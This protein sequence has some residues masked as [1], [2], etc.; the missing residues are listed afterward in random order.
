MGCE[1]YFRNGVVGRRRQLRLEPCRDVR[2]ELSDGVLLA[3]V[4]GDVEGGEA[5]LP[6][7]LTQVHV[8]L[9]ELVDQVHVAVLG[10]DVDGSVAHLRGRAKE[11]SNARHMN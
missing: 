2:E 1:Y 9:R 8:T 5:R 7:Q 10:R 4:G 3:V 6:A 11:P